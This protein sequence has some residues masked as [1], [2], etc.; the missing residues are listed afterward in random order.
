[1]ARAAV[2]I[3]RKLQ[4]AF[5][6]VVALLI[7]IGAIG[8]YSLGQANHRAE[9]L[10]DLQ[11]KVSIYRQLQN[12]INI[13]LYGGASVLS[14]PAP[15]ALDAA[16]RALNQSYDFSR[17]QFVAQDDGQ[18]L[19]R[20]EAT[21]NQFATVMTKGI[22][23]ARQGKLA[24]GQELQRASA[25]PLAD[26]LERL[27]NQLVNKAEA[28]IANLVEDNQQAYRSSRQAFIAIALGG[29]ALALLL[30]FAIS[31]SIIGPIKKMGLRFD[32]LAAGDFSSHVDV[33][34]RDELG[35]LAAN[36]NRM[37]DE[38]GRLY[39]DLETTSRH[40]SEFLANMSHELRT[41]LNA[42]IGFSEVLG[43]QLF[44][45][46]NERQADYVADIVS[47]GRHLLLLIN[48]ILDLSKV[49]AGKMELELSTFRLG[50]VL[51]VGLTMVRERA[52]AHGITLDLH[53]GDAVDDIEAD[54][55]KIKQV[56]FNLLSNAVKFTPDGGTVEVL[57]AHDGDRV[58]VAVR[59]T[60]FGIAPA[61][62]ARIFE[63]FEQTGQRE[64][65]GLGLPLARSFV[66]LHGGELEVESEP[67][68]GSTFTVTLPVRQTGPARPTVS[69]ASAVLAA[70]A[71]SVPVAGESNGGRANRTTV[72]VV[73]D[74]EHSAA[75]LSLHLEQAGFDV[76]ACG[77]AEAGI[78]AARRLR[79]TA[80][81][82]DIVLP[83]LSGWDFLALA[84]GD[85]AIA[86]IPVVI[87]SSL[88]ERGKGFALGAADWLV[89]PVDREHLLATLRPLV[90]LPGSGPCRVLAIDDDPMALRLIETVLAPEG[91][92]VVVA[93][94]GEEG[95]RTAKAERPDLIIL[96]LLM[97]GMDG[98]AVV[99]QLRAEES[100]AAIPVVIL[101]SKTLDARERERL[102]AQ[103]THL[104]TKASFSR[105]EFVAL[106]RRTC[107]RGVEVTR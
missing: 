100:T 59:D 45:P 9:G 15:D 76:V 107:E 96:D 85:E 83:R 102:A 27:T 22:K 60:G 36:L 29:V 14:D 10:S 62:Q 48:D 44:G 58:Q 78:E 93:G 81:V 68:V 106:V 82:L 71:D 34:N 5:G 97:P 21:Y 77:D 1:M 16:Q 11:G 19:T 95:V 72:L 86:H 6:A 12:D 91:F 46:L 84:K 99:E 49:E 18:L 23:L 87:V 101:T 66:V 65:T 7:T 69:V 73:E 98:F 47:S 42:I 32:E 39:H 20:I 2:P 41:P 103:L 38:L 30:G 35:T 63:E 13:K 70:S 67:G 50:E 8:L 61:D 104:A 94:S 79:P 25:K 55:R 37:N 40:K 24:R 90:T 51:E 17:L 31:W 28:D 33:A 75:L 54:E 4:V 89:K 92:T 53:I 105:A 74:D 52:M 80:I 64:G 88:D 3:R 26:Q 43:E 56:V 57:A